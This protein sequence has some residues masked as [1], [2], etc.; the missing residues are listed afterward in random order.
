MTAFIHILLLLASS[1]VMSSV[2]NDIEHSD[3]SNSVLFM[4][5]A[6]AP[7]FG[8]PHNFDINDCS[9]QRG[10]NQQ[11]REQAISIGKKLRQMGIL[12]KTVYSSFWCRCLDT[13]ELLNIGSVQTH[14][15]LNSY[16]QGIVDRKNT[17]K[18]LQ[19]LLDN[20]SPGDGPYLMVTHQVVISDITNRFTSSG[21]IIQYN[22]NNG[23]ASQFKLD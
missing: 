21:E 1:L 12:P 16:F 22:L 18:Q 3:L 4:R 2:A 10:L 17:L 15:G 7:G 11:G 20:L 6:L 8:D 23:Q 9:T 19:N 13:A 14:A 5:H